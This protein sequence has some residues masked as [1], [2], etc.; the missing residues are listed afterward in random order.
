M[1]FGNSF[2]STKVPDFYSEF[3]VQR[4]IYVDVFAFIMIFNELTGMKCQSPETLEMK[5]I[6]EIV[7]HLS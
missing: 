7:S 6:V 3:V 2:F 4:P 1:D 5:D